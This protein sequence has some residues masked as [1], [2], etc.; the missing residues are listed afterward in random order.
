MG[1]YP[2]AC[3]SHLQ[4]LIRNLVI[5][6]GIRR[7]TAGGGGPPRI[8]EMEEKRNKH[9]RLPLTLSSDPRP[10]PPAPPFHSQEGISCSVTN[11]RYGFHVNVVVMQRLRVCKRARFCQKDTEPPSKFLRAAR[12][13]NG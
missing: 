5:R 4:V 6:S 9:P 3:V 8:R 11:V 12:L 13:T 2:Q 10:N 7:C 1:F